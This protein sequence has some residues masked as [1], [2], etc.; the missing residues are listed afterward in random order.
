[1]SN[2][3][4]QVPE[5]EASTSVCR[6]KSSMASTSRRQRRERRFRRY[7]SAGRLVRAQALLQRH[8]GLDVDAGQPPPLHRACARHDAPALCLLLRLGA[9]PAHQD[10]HGDTALHAAARQGPDAYT[11]FFLPLLS[12]CPSAMG[13]KNKDGETPGQILGWGPPWDSAE[14][15]EEDEASK[16]R[17]WRQK[18]QG[19]LEDEWQEVLG[20]F[21]GEDYIPIYSCPSSPLAAFPTP[22]AWMRHTRLPLP[23]SSVLP[24]LPWPISFLQPLSQLSPSHPAKQMT[25]PMRPRN[26]SPSQPGQTAWPGSIPRSTSNS[27]NWKQREPTD[28]SGL[29]APA[30]VG[31][32]RRR[33]SGSSESE[34]GPRR[35]NCVRAEPGGPRRLVGTKGQSQPGLG[36]GRSIQEG[37]GGADSGAL[38][39]YPG[40]ALGEGTQRPWP[41]PWWPGAP[42]WRSRGL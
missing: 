33:N 22:A 14:E 6:P 32:S 21:E 23:P 41:Q 28:P 13:I 37:Q 35:R 42:P 30:T 9:D 12:R 27:S 3:S 4:P 39:M 2:P 31:N 25:C 15:E 26:P 18:L 29:R 19:E 24:Y 5:G 34:P 1:M 17:E 16:E 7:L 10:R 38:A 36:P 8:P 11:D 40:P 20:R